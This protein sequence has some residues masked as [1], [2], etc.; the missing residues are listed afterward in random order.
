MSSELDQLGIAQSLSA[1]ENDE[2]LQRSAMDPVELRGA[3]RA[4]VAAPHLCTEHCRHGYDLDRVPGRSRLRR[5]RLCDWQ[6][7]S[8]MRFDARGFDTVSITAADRRCDVP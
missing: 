7:S 3:Q 8:L 1:D 4:Y 6:N 2:M 5:L